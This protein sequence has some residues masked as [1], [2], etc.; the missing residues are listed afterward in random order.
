M[1][2]RGNAKRYTNPS[3]YRFTQK[4]EQALRKSVKNFNRRI[5]AAIKRNL[6]DFKS[7]FPEKLTFEQVASQVRAPKDVTRQI[8]RLGKYSRKGLEI[9]EAE[10]RLITSASLEEYEQAIRAENRRRQKVKEQLQ[11]TQEMRG[12]FRTGLIDELEP[13]TLQQAFRR[14]EKSTQELFLP[15]YQT[16]YVSER[17]VLWQQNYL[18]YLDGIKEG[19]RRQGLLTEEAENLLNELYNLVQTLPPDK[20]EIAMYENPQFEIEIDYQVAF[21]VNNIAYILSIWRSY[22]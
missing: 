8:K 21:F 3:G 1:A 22:Q 6:P 2:S 19:A 13:I 17:L 5:Q 7:A 14:G 9:T 20:F 10:G 4:Q 16:G 15:L 11:R 18:K 12:R